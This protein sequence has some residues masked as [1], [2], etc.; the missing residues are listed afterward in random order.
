M[1]G[2]LPSGPVIQSPAYSWVPPVAT[3]RCDAKGNPAKPMA[4][5]QTDVSL[6]G[7]DWMARLAVQTIGQTAPMVPLSLKAV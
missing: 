3:G 4:M 2:P 6:T 5:K 1:P 7:A